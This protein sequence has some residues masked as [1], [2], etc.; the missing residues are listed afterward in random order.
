MEP[1]MFTYYLYQSQL[2]FL[3]FATKNIL[4]HL[5][6]N[7]DAPPTFLAPIFECLHRDRQ[8]VSLLV[9]GLPTY[10]PSLLL[11]DLGLAL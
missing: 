2:E 11:T 10:S 4:L 3:L 1:Y 6:L 5:N 9:L 7:T 8:L